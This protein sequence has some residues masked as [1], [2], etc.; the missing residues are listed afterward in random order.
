[1]APERI[2][3]AERA[4]RLARAI[5][6][7]VVLYNPERVRLGIEHDDVFERL[8]PELEE[9]HTYYASRVDPEVAR[10]SGAWG[11]ALV[12]VLVY[13]SGHVRSQIW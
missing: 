8:G 1:M 12:D 5:V 13:R 9:A 2:V 10:K 7:D 4:R 3:D 6:S 11:S